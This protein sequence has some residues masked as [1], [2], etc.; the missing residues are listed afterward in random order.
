MTPFVDHHHHRVLYARRAARAG[1]DRLAE[2]LAGKRHRLPGSGAEHTHQSV[3][4]DRR[5]G[6]DAG[7]LGNVQSSLTTT[8]SRLAD[9]QTALTAPGLQSAEDVD[10]AADALEAFAGA[11]ADAGLL[12]AD[13]VAERSVAGKIPACFR[14]ES[15]TGFMGH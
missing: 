13:C 14:H 10:M 11:D 7:V 2:Q 12:S 5:D 1:H 6:A 15:D 8:Q 9:T 3:G 4:G